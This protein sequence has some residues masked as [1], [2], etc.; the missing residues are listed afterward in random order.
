M[1]NET[2]KDVILGML[3]DRVKANQ[4]GLLSLFQAVG[5]DTDDVV[6]LRDLNTLRKTSFDDFAVAIATLFPES[7]VEA[8]P[9]YLYQHASENIENSDDR[10]KRLGIDK[11]YKY[12]Y[13]IDNF[14]G[15]ET[16][17]VSYKTIS[18]Y[19][20]YFIIIV[21]CAALLYYLYKKYFKSK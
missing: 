3:E 11:D 16:Q 15:V 19:L 21:A 7:K 17:M 9:A 2:D 12:A 1:N 14:E 4:H 18:K 13:D 6:K 8:S 5:I 20:I 10:I